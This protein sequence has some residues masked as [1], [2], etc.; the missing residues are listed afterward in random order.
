MRTLKRSQ[1]EQVNTAI[2]R[3]IARRT[4]AT[5]N[6]D[7]LIDQYHGNIDDTALTC[8]LTK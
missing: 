1:S 4:F 5:G 2:K 3:E 7:A 8:L 6:V